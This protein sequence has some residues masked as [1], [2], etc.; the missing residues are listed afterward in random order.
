MYTIKEIVIWLSLKKKALDGIW[1]H[2]L[3]TDSVML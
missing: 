1:T 3:H 2:D